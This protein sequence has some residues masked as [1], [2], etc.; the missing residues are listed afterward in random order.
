MKI[1]V[2]DDEPYIQ[3]SLSYI[4]R[5]EG[6]NVEVASNGE[7]AIR[8]IREFRPGIVFVD[9]VMPKMDGFNVCRTIKSDKELKST[10]V[11]ILTA[12]GQE[13]DRE[14]GLKEGA[15]EFMTKPFSPKE[16]IS[17]VHDIFREHQ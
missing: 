13:V 5:K 2:A 14:R 17:R 9:L 7:E 1:L 10:Y 11:I 12:K 8:K 4:L 6:F 15:D 16:V 3:L